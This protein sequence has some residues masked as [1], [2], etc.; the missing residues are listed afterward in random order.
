MTM[1]GDKQH[2][3][4]TGTI[5]RTTTARAEYVLPE[6]SFYVPHLTAQMPL[7]LTKNR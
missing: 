5:A 6:A 1:N 4:T 7:L 3:A 2:A